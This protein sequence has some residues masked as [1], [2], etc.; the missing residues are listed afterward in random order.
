MIA[1]L[2]TN[3]LGRA[4]F[5]P[6][7][8]IRNPQKFRNPEVLSEKG[9][10]GTADTLVGID[11]RYRDV[12]ASLLGRIVVADNVDNAVS[13]AAK[14]RHSLRIVTLE[15]ELLV[16]GGAISGGAYRNNSNLLGRRREIEA[17][18]ERAKKLYS[19][20]AGINQDIENTKARRTRMRVDLEA[21]KNEIQ[22]KSI[23]QNTVR[24]NIA[25]ARARMEEEVESAFSLQEE[26]KEIE[27]KILE[28]KRDKEKTRQELSDSEA[29]EKSTQEEIILW[30]KSLEEERKVETQALAAA[31]EWDLKVEKMR[32]TLEFKQS[33]VDRI[34]GEIE[35]SVQSWRRFFRLWRT[36]AWRWREGSGV[37]L[38]SRKR[39]PRLLRHRTPPKTD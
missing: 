20:I 37:S 32:Q 2:K 31:S 28:I 23:E 7:T 27:E 29:L 25:Q 38:R 11:E 35:N 34:N 24:L 17:L 30:Q 14:Y 19:A 9:V 13:L 36:T 12:A 39:L 16:P 3:K 26:E 1:F 6:L 21:I 15:G 33:N 4:T 22:R 18:E 5:L 8:S 10:I